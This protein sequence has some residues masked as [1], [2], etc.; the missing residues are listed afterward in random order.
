MPG[1]PPPGMPP[2]GMRPGMPP[3]GM[4][5]GGAPP[6]MPPQFMRGPP[7]PGMMGG[8]PPMMGR[9]A[10][11]LVAFQG[12]HWFRNASPAWS[13]DCIEDGA[14]LPV[15]I[16]SISLLIFYLSFMEII[17]KRPRFPSQ[18]ISN[19]SMRSCSVDLQS[20]LS[21]LPLC[22]FSR[23]SLHFFPMGQPFGFFFRLDILISVATEH[24]FLSPREGWLWKC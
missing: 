22:L 20:S 16:Y 5:M 14:P 9:G 8:P 11:N 2:P 10:L 7:P 12:A 6:G 18:K 3:P 17:T 21:S 13:I 4:P 24:T 1:M 19:T 23:H 15:N